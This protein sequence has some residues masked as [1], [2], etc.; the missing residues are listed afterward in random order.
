MPLRV[1]LRRTRD[2]RVLLA[3]LVG[4]LLC[5]CA[6]RAEAT[7]YYVDFQ[8]GVDSAPGTQPG[9]A[10]KHAPGD[11]AATDGPSSV[12]LRPGD[13]VRFRGGVA[14]RGVITIR[15]S[16]AD[17]A[18]IVYAGD[19]WGDQSAV[20]DG[21]DP[22]TSIA[23]CSSAGVCGGASNW[24]E[25]SLLEFQPPKTTL[26]KFFDSTGPLFEGQFPRP[27]D[28]F[29]SDDTAEYAEVPLSQAVAA[30]QGEL[31][32]SK[33]A[34]TLGP[35]VVGGALSLWTMGNRVD[36]RPITGVDGDRIQFS[37]N[38][39]RFYKDRPGRAA[40]VNSVALIDR[41]GLYA[42][43]APGRAVAWL[44]PTDAAG[45]QALW[46]GSGRTAIDFKG[47]SDVVVRGFI[48]ERF[49]A[50]KYGEGVQITNSGSLSSRVRVEDNIFR[51]SA[52]YTGAGPIM[53]GQ[54]D[55][56]QITNNTFSEIE[57]GS[58]IRTNRKPVSN[59]SI[60]GNR[61]ERL[62]QTG[63]LVMGASDSIVSKNVM[64]GFYGIH[65][66]GIS[67]YLD[68]RRVT[69]SDNTVVGATRPLTFHGDNGKTPD[70]N[71]LVIERNVLVTEEPSAGAITSYGGTRGVKI[72]DNVLIGPR[73]GLLLAP[74]DIGIVASNN[75]TSGIH[76]KGDQPRAWVLSGNKGVSR[77][78]AAAAA[79]AVK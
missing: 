23:A 63:I 71:D 72:V 53:I 55:G 4:L 5:G 46:V 49:V 51:R 68:N 1:T 29:F 61:F 12:Q 57:R 74:T 36:R 70:N 38:G 33:L 13:R 28:P 11:A 7:V 35:N 17:G 21:S 37:P 75:S 66:N 26:I 14:Y 48:F 19:E 41:P 50:A 73:Y 59:L 16:G 3:P 52:L 31:K 78:Q 47:Q 39:V 22:V 44:R 54:V 10:W 79:A 27:K 43:I 76:T 77:A 20:F 64:T 32:S 69:A 24:A 6:P 60:V 45:A 2:L 67:L 62:G 9:Q 65:G 34:K 25:L 42:V 56:A 58:G 30:E 40:I 8:N 15:A 18:P